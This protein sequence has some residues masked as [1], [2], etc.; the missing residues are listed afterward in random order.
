MKLFLHQMKLKCFHLISDSSESGNSS[1]T[2]SSM[3]SGGLDE[4]EFISTISSL[5]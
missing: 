5:I 2:I 1:F 3:T 4:V